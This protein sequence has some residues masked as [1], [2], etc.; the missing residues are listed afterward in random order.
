MTAAN[1]RRDDAARQAWRVMADLVLDNERKRELSEETGLSFGKTRA[2]RRIIDRP[3][4]MGE[5]ADLLGVDRPNLT[6]IVDDLE[7]AGLVRRRDHPTDR[8]VILV[9]ATPAGARLARRA[10]EIMDRPPLGLSELT[11]A[12]LETLLR[13]L[14]R[15]RRD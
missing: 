3:V 13:L 4:P 10:E 7:R 1:S 8:R 11:V 9:A 12:D 2:L 15:I 6:T 5:L 14:S